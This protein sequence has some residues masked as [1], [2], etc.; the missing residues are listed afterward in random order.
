MN[1]PSLTR[2]R[3]YALTHLPVPRTATACI[4]CKRKGCAPTVH[5]RC[6]ALLCSKAPTIT[7]RITP[8]A[9]QLCMAQKSRGREGWALCLLGAS[10]RQGDHSTLQ[11]V[12]C[13]SGPREYA[14][15]GARGGGVGADIFFGDRLC[16]YGSEVLGLQP[17]VRFLQRNLALT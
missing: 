2:G 1:R 12:P 11:C 16:A 4:G 14:L 8:G 10:V 3:R 5:S 13:S 15:C 6:F 17:I 7:S 9:R